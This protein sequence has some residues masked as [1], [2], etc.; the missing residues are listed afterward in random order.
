MVYNKLKMETQ[1]KSMIAAIMALII[2]LGV[3]GV[4]LQDNTFD[5]YYICS[6]SF[7]T[8]EFARL[9]GTL[10]TAYPNEI[11]NVGRIRCVD[12][13]GIRGTWQSVSEYAAEHN[14]DIATLIKPDNESATIIEKPIDY[15]Q[16]AKSYKCDNLGCE[17]IK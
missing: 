8:G 16:T 7:Q 15:T 4:N 11:N 1:N 6:S 10:Y 5:N 9:S 2:S 14:I 13:Q 3:V 12:E 17:E